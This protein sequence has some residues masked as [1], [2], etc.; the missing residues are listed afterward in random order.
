MKEIGGYFQLEEMPGEEYYPDLYRVNLGRTALLW[1]LKSRRC[2]KNPITVF[3]V[4]I[5]GAYL[6]GKSDRDRILSSE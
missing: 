4:W 3:S 5:S 2:R 1:L 6:S